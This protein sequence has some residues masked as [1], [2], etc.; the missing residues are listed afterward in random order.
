MTHVFGAPVELHGLVKQLPDTLGSHVPDLMIDYL[1]TVFTDDD[2][3]PV[4]R[5]GH[6]RT[7]ASQL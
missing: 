6:V 1:A 7:Y 2:I 3:Q 5:W 4:A